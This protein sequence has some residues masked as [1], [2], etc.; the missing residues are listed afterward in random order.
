MAT[1]LSKIACHSCKKDTDSFLSAT[2]DTKD[3][4]GTLAAIEKGLSR[5][6]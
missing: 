1:D 5:R 6:D 2:T 3:F 4:S